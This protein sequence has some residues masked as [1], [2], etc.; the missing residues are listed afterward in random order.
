M[1]YDLEQYGGSILEPETRWVGRYD[2]GS[3]YMEF[4]DTPQVTEAAAYVQICGIQGAVTDVVQ[5]RYNDQQK[6]WVELR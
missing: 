3:G 2:N 4:V 1:I 6:M 5:V